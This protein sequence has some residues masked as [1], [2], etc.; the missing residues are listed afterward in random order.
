M[1]GILVGIPI[2]VG[3]SRVA[4]MATDLNREAIWALS[5][6]VGVVVVVVAAFYV[7]RREHGL[8]IET[9]RLSRRCAEVEMRYRLL[10][11]NSVDVI[12]H[13]RGREITWISQSVEAALGWRSEQLIGSDFSRYV[14][15]DDFDAVATVLR[16]G[17][18]GE[19][20]DARFRV[21]KASGGY[22]WVDVHGKPY[23]DAAGN[24]DGVI[25]AARIVDEQIEAEQKLAAAR[26][27]FEAVANHAPSAISVRDLDDRYTM[28]NEAFCK[29]FGQEAV[30][31]VI[32]RTEEEILAPDVLEHS[33]IARAE[34]LSG[35]GG[36][37]EESISEGHENISVMTQRF[38]LRNA[39]G[40]IAE[41]VTIRT[42]ITHRKK[43]EREAAERALWEERI[44]AAIADGRLLVYAQPIV[45]IATR[46]TVEEELLVRLSVAG[47]EEILPPGAFLPQC[48]QYRLMPAIDQYMVG[49]AIELAR[50]GRRV[51]VNITGQTIGDV[52]AMGEIFESLTDAGTA[53]SGRIAFEITETTALASPGVAKTF[54]S[55]MRALGCQ[56][57]LDDFGTGYGAFTE[58]RHLDLDALKIDLS[59]VQNMLQ[60][61]EDER[62]VKT[63]VSVARA[64]GLATVAEGVETEGTLERLAELGV[65]RA[66][67]Y[68]FR[69]PTAIDW[70]QLGVV[71]Q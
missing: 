44:G 41:L 22:R 67:G 29:L 3:F 34:L 1:L 49:R 32:G 63:I 19:P 52:T 43:I 57:S 15:R 30:E 18:R 7:G 16:Q 47:A 50:C 45:N 55:G 9:E 27:R 23:K 38:L 35:N 11:D 12:A 4:L 42:D 51:C 59:F 10:A 6:L 64:Y 60:D 28:V 5:T 48:Q 70:Q 26:E 14:H 69:R 2:L 39:T 61:P 66:Q 31:D 17:T 8:R 25:F 53:V 24:T 13:L 62:A 36:V 46:E 21:Q 37:E 58:L 68:L 71:A 33:R 65:D 56:V 40:A 20:A 54:S